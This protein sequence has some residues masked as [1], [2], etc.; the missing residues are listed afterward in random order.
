MKTKY[1]RFASKMRDDLL[2]KLK[3]VSAIEGKQIQALL[4]EAVIQYLETRQVKEEETNDGKW[5]VRF[6]MTPKDPDNQNEK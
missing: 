6:S 3:V 5:T 2:R 1:K 4:E